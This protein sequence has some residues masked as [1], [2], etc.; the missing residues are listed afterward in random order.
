M[1][2]AREQRAA[3][4][5]A[6]TRARP[7]RSS[8]SAAGVAEQA[9]GPVQRHARHVQVPGHVL[10][11][12]QAREPVEQHVR[13]RGRSPSGVHGR[14]GR[15]GRSP[16][17]LGHVATA[18]AQAGARRRRRTPPARRRS[19]SA[20]ASWISPRPCRPAA[21]ARRTG[22][23]RRPPRRRARRSRSSARSRSTSICSPRSWAV[24]QPCAVGQRGLGAGPHVRD[25]EVVTKQVEAPGAG[26]SLGIRHR[27]RRAIGLA[28]VPA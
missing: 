24:T 16:G 10:P 6:A 14:H 21:P 28:S 22:P 20:R 1:R 27:R 19:G 17:Q 26:T 4:L 23:R 15:C 18:G 5:R 9:S 12:Q 2:V 11:P 13:R 7:T 25:A 3:R 8:P